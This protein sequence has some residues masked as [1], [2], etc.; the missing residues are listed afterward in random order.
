ML[1]DI[2]YGIANGEFHRTPL[3]PPPRDVHRDEDIEE[4]GGSGDGAKYGHRGQGI[5][6]QGAAVSVGATAALAR[7]IAL[8]EYFKYLIFKK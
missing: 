1:E 6:H 2:R 7:I 8:E 3:L 5:D 4:E